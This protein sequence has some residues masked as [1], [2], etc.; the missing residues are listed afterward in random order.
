MYLRESSFFVFVFFFLKKYSMKYSRRRYVMSEL[1]N[2][3]VYAWFSY[4]CVF[5]YREKGDGGKRAET[6]AQ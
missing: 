1:K 6:E 4:V 5:L 2:S 3:G